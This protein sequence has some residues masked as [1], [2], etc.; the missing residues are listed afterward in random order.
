MSQFRRDIFDLRRILLVF[1]IFRDRIHRSRPVQRY[2]CDDILKAGWLQVLHE[3]CHS[4]RFKLEYALRVPACDEVIDGFVVI[5]HFRDVYRNS[6]VLFDHSESV[7]DDREVS[8]SEEVHLQKP[9]L[10]DRG[11]VELCR[12]AAV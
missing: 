12:D 1:Y 3:R 10:L 6:V 4:T 8:E 7:A 5:S 11:H 9:E 2:P